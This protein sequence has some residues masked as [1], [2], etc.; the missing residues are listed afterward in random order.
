MATFKDACYHYRKLNKLNG[1]VLKLG[2]ND[3]WRPAPIAKYKGWCLDCCQHTDLTY[4]RG[5]ALFHVCQWCSQYNRCF[6]DE[7]PHLLRMRTFRNQ[8]SRKDIEGLI[9]MYN[10]LFPINERI[11]DKFISNVK[12]RR[13]RNEFL[14]EWYN[15]L[16][17]PITLQALMVELEGDV[18]YIFGYFDH[19]EKENQTPFQFV[20]MINNYDKLLLDDKNFDRM[21]NLPVILQQEYA[22]RYFSKS[23]FISK[24]KKSVNRHDFANN[25]MEEMDNPI[26]LM[27]V[28]RNCVNEYM[29]DKNWNE[30]CTLIVDMKSYMELMKSSYT[31]HYSVSQRCKLFTIYKLNIISKLIKPNYI[32]S[33]H[34][35]H[36]LDVHNCKWCQMNNHYKI[37]DDF[38]LK[39][40]YNNTMC[41]IRALMKSN[42]NVGHRSSQEV[43]YEYMSNIFIVWKNEK[44]N[45]SMQMIF[46]Y[47]EPVE[48]SGIEYIL[49]DHE[50]SWEIRGI[51]MQIMNGE[52]PRILTFNDVKKIIS[53]IIYDW[54]DVRYMREMPLIISTTNELRKMNKRND[55]M[56]E[57]SYEL[58]D[59]E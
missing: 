58:S 31:E 26:S 49:L 43:V 36:A 50:L 56:D 40:V 14:I 9:N 18:Y 23:R 13:C 48:I 10:T 19:M 51:V 53:A 54:F 38:R 30:K 20:N 46:D 16:L 47:L 42:K 33:N 8:I 37:W 35:A 11:V 6:L 29:D 5:C 59:T 45:K 3:A 25:L 2:A 15:H 27:Q 4:C 22:F 12:Q 52:I 57:Y 1:L 41:F 55:L 39:K 21:T 44:W 34:G 17:L 28:M 32:F 24:T 7:E